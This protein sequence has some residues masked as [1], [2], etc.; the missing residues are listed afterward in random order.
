MEETRH[1][2]ILLVDDPLAGAGRLAGDDF[3]AAEPSPPRPNIVF[4]LADDLGWADVGFHGG[5][6]KTP[7]LDEL[8]ASGARLE[9]FYVQPVCSPTRAALMTGRYPDAPRPAGGRGPALGPVRPAAGGTHAAA[10]AEGG[11]LRDGHLRQVAPG[12][13]PAAS[14]CR[15]AAASTTSTATTTARSTTSPTIAT[16]AST[17]IATTRRAATRATAPTCWPTRRCD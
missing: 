9:Q 13:L 8:A 1:V 17:G 3:A 16:A 6:I 12:P 5:E 4:I 15:P 11:G 10:G 7:H 14:T 2:P